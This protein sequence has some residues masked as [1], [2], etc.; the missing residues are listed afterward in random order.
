V[1][2]AEDRA[3]A[4]LQQVRRASRRRD[5]ICRAEP[6]RAYDAQVNTRK[7]AATVRRYQRY[8][9]LR[10]LTCPE[11]NDHYLLEPA[12]VAGDVLLVCPTCGYADLLT[13]EQVA[14]LETRAARA[15]AFWR[16]IPY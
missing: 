6:A 15:A 11:G 7:A 1:S 4:R 9:A 5:G 13:P 16:G 10:P 3:R 2:L 14:F 12:V 8:E